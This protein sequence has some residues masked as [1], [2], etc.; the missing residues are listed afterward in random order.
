MLVLAGGGVVGGLVLLG[1]GF[2]GYRDAARIT[3]TSPSRIASI[4][5]GE[6]LVSGVV[7]AAELTL[8]SPLQSATCVFYRSRTSSR[9]TTTASTGLPGGGSRRV[10]GPG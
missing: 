6:V 2:G 9:A 3:D 5:V 10:P 7:E 8:V 4:A 1:R